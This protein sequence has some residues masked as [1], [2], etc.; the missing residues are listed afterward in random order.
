MAEDKLPSKEQVKWFMLGGLSGMAL[1][2]RESFIEKTKS[3]L[4]KIVEGQDL[5]GCLEELIEEGWVEHIEEGDNIKT[6]TPEG[7]STK[8][9]I[10]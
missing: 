7:I 2:D 10:E 4:G 6:T 8:E 1:H 5:E 9:G 3:S